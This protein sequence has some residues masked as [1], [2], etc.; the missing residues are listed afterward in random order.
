[1]RAVR[2]DWISNLVS[3]VN[4]IPPPKKR[5]LLRPEQMRNRE[6]M[7]HRRKT[8]VFRERMHERLLD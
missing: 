7:E 6:K 3:E 5:L 8:K 2:I 1:M 4:P